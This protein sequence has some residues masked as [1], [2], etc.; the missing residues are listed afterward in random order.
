MLTGESI[1]EK[2]TVSAGQNEEVEKGDERFG[3]DR[4]ELDDENGEVDDLMGR[5]LFVNALTHR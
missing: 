2:S 1:E 4:D 5:E 3:G